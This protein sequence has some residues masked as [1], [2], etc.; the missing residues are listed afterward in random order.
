[1][2]FKIQKEIS[3]TGTFY[4]TIP[5]SFLFRLWYDFNPLS[6]IIDHNPYDCWLSKEAAIQHI[7]RYNSGYYKKTYY[8]TY[9]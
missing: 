4:W 8:K 9:V 2:K 5:K 3:D 1:M 6:I 7:K